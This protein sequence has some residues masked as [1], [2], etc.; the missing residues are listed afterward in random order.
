MSST[1]HTDTHRLFLGIKHSA[2]STCHSEGWI[3]INF[4]VPVDLT[5]CKTLSSIQQVAAPYLTGSKAK[6]MYEKSLYKFRNILGPGQYVLSR[7]PNN[8][9]GIKIRRL[10]DLSSNLKNLVWLL[11]KRLDS[12]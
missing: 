11:Y 10:F 9:D 6:G 2:A 1:N 4:N 7:C 5:A 12:G 8:S 3:G